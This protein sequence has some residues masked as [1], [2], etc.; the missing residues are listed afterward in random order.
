MKKLF[1]AGVGGVIFFGQRRWRMIAL[2]W[3]RHVHGGRSEADCFQTPAF[4]RCRLC[5]GST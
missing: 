1:Y 3:R 2:F 5:D 4:W